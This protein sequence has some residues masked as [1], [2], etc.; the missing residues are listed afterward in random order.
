MRKQLR[1][2]KVK[3]RW[4]RIISFASAC[5]LILSMLIGLTISVLNDTTRN[6][7][8]ASK[9]SDNNPVSDTQTKIKNNLTRYLASVTS[10]G[11]VAVDFY[12]L[13]PVSGSQAAQESNAAVYTEGSLAV[14]FNGTQRM[15]AASTYKLYI[16]AWLFHEIKVGAITWT[17][18]D[19][20]GFQRMIINSDNDYSEAILDQYGAKVLNK[21]Y[22]TLGTGY[23]FKS[24]GATTTSNDLM[25]ILKAIQKGTGP[26]DNASLRKKLLTAMENQVYRDGIPA[27]AEQVASGS[28]VQD[29]V[30]WIGSTDNDAGIVTTPKGDRYLLVIMTD[31]GDYQDFSQIEKIAS[32][33]QTIVYGKQ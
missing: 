24:S 32:K 28:T 4:N 10:N 14:S 25:T 7:S 3:L 20:D 1:Q 17:D 16:T 6:T 11:N 18:N 26:F 27:A 13:S 31:N 8:A 22:A 21:Y 5:I 9:P 23:V 2:K 30:G 19:E 12:N 15:I 29:K 33:I